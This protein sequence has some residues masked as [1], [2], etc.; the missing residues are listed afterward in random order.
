MAERLCLW[1]FEDIP[2][3]RTRRAE[4][5]TQR[6]K[7]QAEENRKRRRQGVPLAREIK[8]CQHCR[9]EYGSQK[10]T[11]KYCSPGCKLGAVKAKRHANQR[12]DTL[13]DC[14]YCGQSFLTRNPQRKWCSSRCYEVARYQRHNF[15]PFEKR[16]R[17]Y[18][19]CHCC[20]TPFI[21]VRF[22]QKYCGSVCRDKARWMPKPQGPLCKWCHRPLAGPATKQFCDQRCRVQFRESHQVGKESNR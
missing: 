22:N 8:V 16:D 4:Y 18:M 12:T 17:R 5:C 9:D 21:S 15:R 11:Q 13:K 3:T 20:S 14:P 10:A 6:C 19:A 1:C 2:P 7:K